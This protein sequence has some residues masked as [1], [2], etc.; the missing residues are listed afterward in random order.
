MAT[1]DMPTDS[2]RIA[3]RWTKAGPVAASMPPAEILQLEERA[4]V[5]TGDPTPMGL[6][7]FA[8]GTLLVGVVIAG[9]ISQ[10]PGLLATV[11]I[12]LLFAGVAQ[13]IAGLFAYAKSNTF[14]GTAMC[15]YGTNNAAV[16]VFLLLQH[17]GVIQQA[18]GNTIL[19]WWLCCFAFISFV[20]GIAAFRVSLVLVGV[21][22]LLVPGFAL[23]AIGADWNVGH[24]LATVGGWCL[25]ASAVLAFYA[26]SAIVI[27]SVFTREALPFGTTLARR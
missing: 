25:V 8:T 4:E 17:A 7:G 24:V 19:G 2:V 18:T 15:S 26:A 6:F 10:T 5:V 20:L 21:I 23:T 12:V 13:F 27:N 11:P 3:Q 14:A 22:W 16:A 1:N 9:V